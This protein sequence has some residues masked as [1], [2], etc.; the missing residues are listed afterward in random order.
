[1]EMYPNPILGAAM[2]HEMGHIL[3][4]AGHSPMGIMKPHWNEHDLRGVAWH[5]L[6]FTPDEAKHLRTAAQ[7]L[8]N[9]IAG[10]NGKQ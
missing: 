7:H 5:Q 10:A 8:R 1:M 4:G 2:A 3:L 9:G 6:L